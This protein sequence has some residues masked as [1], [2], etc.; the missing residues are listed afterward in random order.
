MF[1]LAKCDARVIRRLDPSSFNKVGTLRIFQLS[2]NY[3]ANHGTFLQED[4]STLCY[5]HVKVPN[6]RT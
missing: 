1:I 2:L 5:Y 3:L 4:I 6:I